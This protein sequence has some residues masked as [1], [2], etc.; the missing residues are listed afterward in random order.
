MTNYEQK[1]YNFIKKSLEDDS[2]SGARD[3]IDRRIVNGTDLKDMVCDFIIAHDGNVSDDIFNLFVYDDYLKNKELLQLYFKHL[4]DRGS[5]SQYEVEEFAS[6]PGALLK[7]FLQK[8]SDKNYVVNELHGSLLKDDKFIRYCLSN[9]RLDIFRYVRKID[10][11][12]YQDIVNSIERGNG[13][14]VNTIGDDYDKK[15]YDDLFILNLKQGYIGSYLDN[16]IYR[17]DKRVRE[18]TSIVKDLIERDVDI[19]ID[20]ECSSFEGAYEW[21]NYILDNK[22]YKYLFLTNLVYLRSLVDGD[23]IREL[24]MEEPSYY[25]Y[26][27]EFYYDIVADDE[28]LYLKLLESNEMGVLYK[29]DSVHYRKY[30]DVLNK[31][32]IENKCDISD[33]SIIWLLT[34]SDKDLIKTLVKG[35]INNYFFLSDYLKISEPLSRY[36]DNNLYVASRDSISLYY[37]LNRNH[38]DRFVKKFGP[39]YMRYLDNENMR[40]AINLDDKN[41][42][43]YLSLFDISELNVEDVKNIYDSL[44]QYRFKELYKGDISR[45][46]RIKESLTLSDIDSLSSDLGVLAKNIN[47]SKLK[48]IDF[49]EEELKEIESNPYNYLVKICSNIR[50]GIDANRYSDILYNINKQYLML[51]REK[52]R[53]KYNYLDEINLDVSY[54]KSSVRDLYVKYYFCDA[55]LEELDNRLNDVVKSLNGNLVNGIDNKD[56]IKRVIRFISSNG[57]EYNTKEVKSNV[58][59]VKNCLVKYLTDR[60]VLLPDNSLKDLKK[61]Y[62]VPANNSDD[63]F[64]ILGDINPKELVDTVF[65]DYKKTEKLLEYLN[66]YKFIYWKDLFSNTLSNSNLSFDCGSVSSF[67]SKFNEVYNYVN[68]LESNNYSVGLAQLVNFANVLSSSSSRYSLLFGKK[69][70]RLIK[71]NPHPNEG[72]TKRDR[73]KVSVSNLVE[74][75]KRRFITVPPIDKV[76]NVNGK[77]IRVNLGNFTNSIN[78]VYGELSGSCMRIGGEAESL[79]NFCLNNPNGFHLRFSDPENGDFITRASGFRNGNSVFFNELRYSCSKNYSSEDIVSAMKEVATIICSS[80]LNSAFPI[81]NVFI[82]RDFAM[83]SEEYNSYFDFNIKE[84]F[85]PFY[86]DMISNGVCLYTNSLDDDYVPVN[87]DKDGVPY[88]LVLRDGIVRTSNKGEMFS[89]INRFRMLKEMVLKK[90]YSL[91]EDCKLITYDDVDNILYLI[92]GEDFIVYLDKDMNVCYDYF[93]RGDKRMKEEIDLALEEINSKKEEYSDVRGSRKL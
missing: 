44:A 90:D 79:Y 13:F 3:L 84:G 92:S 82:S 67:I 25:K 46:S 32:I 69:N 85:P 20:D 56:L 18:V 14:L 15:M 70:A 11:K 41:F 5:F 40:N 72:V 53:D 48:N 28:E 35:N 76:I 64:S 78:Y 12:Y 52:Y 39:L 60:N 66:K 4:I 58:N 47:I 27:A 22:K 75:Y 93:S 91:F 1:R 54:D 37:G 59:V 74:G 36:Y 51:L 45:L 63:I 33:Y 19:K 2:F 6:D 83:K 50:K 55:S 23:K 68:D 26:F 16:Y 7:Y 80:A 8:V 73:E 88:Y 49:S 24:L 42:E 86:F 30:K 65:S 38:L 87:M 89:I 43:L 10:S 81:D 61:V 9:D 17:N 29:L 62:S 71:L 31:K 21:I 77:D 57:R 34:F